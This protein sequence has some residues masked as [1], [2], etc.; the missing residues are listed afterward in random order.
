[1]NKETLQNYN[2]RLNTNNTSLE[3]VLETINNLPEITETILQDKEVNIDKNGTT[4]VEAD[5]D[6]DGIGSVTINTN[7][8]TPKF[9]LQDKTIEITGNGTTTIKA[10]EGYDGLNNVE[11]T[12]NVAGGGGGE[13]V[14]ADY[15]TD[16]LI[17]WFDAE[18]DFDSSGHWNSRVEGSANYIYSTRTTNASNVLLNPIPKGKYG[19]VS[20][21]VYPLAST[22][23][24]MKP[25]YTIEVVGKVRTQG[26][27][28]NYT[29]T[30]DGAW[31]LTL[32]MSKSAGIGIY[33]A[34]NEISFINDATRQTGYYP[35]YK[36]KFFGA[37]LYLESIY[38]RA[39]TFSGSGSSTTSFKVQ[40]SAHGEPLRY[41]LNLNS[42]SF[43]FK[44]ALT[45]ILSY[46]AQGT[47]YCANGEICCIRIYNRKLTDEEI[48]YNHAIDKA[49]YNLEK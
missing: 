22:K 4:I 44:Q 33:G 39:D 29:T 17:E 9:I 13:V 26:T 27:D 32:N 46:Y 34:N 49:R 14:T 31:L 19:Y 16:G 48:A 42:F 5:E 47:Y 21:C 38:D 40:A 43:S 28:N 10:D 11:V 6:Y 18:D 20:N 3:N 36:D 25:N 7:V 12:T 35:N 1:M 45:P 30:S 2:E 8:E 24:C 41:V 37:T 23:N 15:I